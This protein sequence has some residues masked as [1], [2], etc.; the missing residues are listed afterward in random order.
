MRQTSFQI[1]RC[2]VQEVTSFSCRASFL[3]EGLWHPIDFV[4]HD[5]RKGISCRCVAR[6]STRFCSFEPPIPCSSCEAVGLPSRGRW[7]TS[8]VASLPRVLR[9]SGA[10]PQSIPGAL[11]ACVDSARNLVVILPTLSSSTANTVTYSDC[12]EEV[13][14]V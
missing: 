1:I 12:V 11:D 4:Q 14:T 6:G 5:A 8:L 9:V 2:P 13:N 3:E 10:C 7:D